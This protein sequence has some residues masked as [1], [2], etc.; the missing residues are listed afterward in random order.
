VT[1]NCNVPNPTF[2]VGTASTWTPT[3]NF[4]IT[5]RVPNGFSLSTNVAQSMRVFILEETAANP[6]KIY[7]DDAVLSQGPVTTVTPYAGE[8]ADSGNPT[9]YGNL[10]VAGTLTVGSLPAALTSGTPTAGNCA[11]FASSPTTNVQDNGS[12]C[13]S[14]LNRYSM[15]TVAASVAPNSANTI[16]VSVIYLPNIQFSHLAV[17]VGTTD[18]SNL[19]S[20]AITDLSGNVKCSM[21]AAVNLSS[22]GANDQACSQGTVTLTNGAYIFA[23]TGNATTGKISYSGTAPLALA[24]SASSSTSS[25]GVMTFPISIPLAGASFSSYGLPAILLH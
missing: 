18:A 21:S 17:N 22:S 2:T 16:N 11:A 3:R 25:S 1:C 9:E 10:T 6:N 12:P 15:G 5:F 24:S 19:Y 14:L 7:V 13:P 20:W 8:L 23:F 4:A